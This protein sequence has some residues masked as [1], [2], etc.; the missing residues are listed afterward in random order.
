MVPKPDVGCLWL[1]REMQFVWHF[2]TWCLYRD[3]KS[4]PQD[5]EPIDTD[6]LKAELK[7]WMRKLDVP[8]VSEGYL[9]I[10]RPSFKVRKL[11]AIVWYFVS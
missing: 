5:A 3:W 8:H 6:I 4:R 2:L 11:S 9:T 1:D 10:Y 7:T